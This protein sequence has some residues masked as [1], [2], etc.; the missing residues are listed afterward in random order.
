M[1]GHGVSVL[2][3]AVMAL[4]GC[5][6][7]SPTPEELAAKIRP[8]VVKYLT[9]IDPEGQV[10]AV[11]VHHGGEPVVEH[12]VDSAAEDYWDTRSVTKSVVSTL[13]GIAID[14]GHIE[15]VQ[16][17]PGELLPSR[18]AEMSDETA[19]LTLHQVLTHT[20]GFEPQR[21]GD[22]YYRAED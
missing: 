8:A 2:A 10:R 21:A 5:A 6:A 14:E 19:A 7:T 3:V 13:I 4:T 12:Y 17:T 22:E 20:A 16:Q 11:L 1:R 9:E 15:D 18:V